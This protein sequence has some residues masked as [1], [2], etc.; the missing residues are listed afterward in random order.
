MIGPF[1]RQKIRTRIEEDDIRFALLN[2]NDL[3]DAMASLLHQRI[4][5]DLEGSCV[6]VQSINLAFQHLNYLIV[7]LSRWSI[8][9]YT[10]WILY[11]L[12]EGGL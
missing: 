3:V 10:T 1:R 7:L 5:L 6:L 2:R 8:I 4:Q 12:P 9:L 11:S